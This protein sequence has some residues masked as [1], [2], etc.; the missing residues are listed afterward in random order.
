MA[1]RLDRCYISATM[2]AF[3]DSSKHIYLPSILSDHDAGI[4]FRVRAI[5]LRIVVQAFGS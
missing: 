2:S 1:A 5:M 4:S 3:I